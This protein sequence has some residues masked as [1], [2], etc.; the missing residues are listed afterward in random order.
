MAPTNTGSKP[1]GGPPHESWWET[2][3]GCLFIVVGVVVLAVGL[4]GL[5]AWAAKKDYEEAVDRQIKILKTGNA[6]TRA[7]AIMELASLE[8]QEAKRT[9]PAVPYLIANLPDETP[10]QW[11]TVVGKGFMDPGTS[12]PTNEFTT[13]GKE[14]AKTLVAIGPPAIPQ[15]I[16]AMANRIDRREPIKRI[17]GQNPMQ[18]ARIAELVPEVLAKVGKPAVEPLTKALDDP[19]WGV[20]TGAAEALGLLGDKSAVP[21]LT[22]KLTDPEPAVRAAAGMAL[23]RLGVLPEGGLGGPLKAPQDEQRP[24]R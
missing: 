18:Q 7:N 6:V 23:S 20:R 17:E 22:A 14:A 21:A 11:N 13:P 10:L 5:F 24:P 3:N 16:E 2:P 8:R 12:L 4:I 19:R 15:L 9:L 1:S